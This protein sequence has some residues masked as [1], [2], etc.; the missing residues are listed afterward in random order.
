[1]RSLAQAG[2]L[3]KQRGSA[4]GKMLT[5]NITSCYHLVTEWALSDPGDPWELM[6]NPGRQQTPKRLRCLGV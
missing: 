2:V 4:G 5:Q 6:C 3:V 1:M